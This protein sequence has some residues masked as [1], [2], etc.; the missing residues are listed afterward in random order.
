MYGRHYDDASVESCKR[1]THCAWLGG[2]ACCCCCCSGCWQPAGPAPACSTCASCTPAATCVTHL[3]PAHTHLQRACSAP[4]AHL[5]RGTWHMLR[6]TT[7]NWGL[8]CSPLSQSRAALAS[9][10]TR[11]LYTATPGTEDIQMQRPTIMLHQSSG[12]LTQREAY[13]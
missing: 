1:V 10:P 9:T 13:M 5:P 4:A 12:H 2:R 8:C 6:G 11:V 3:P 7:P